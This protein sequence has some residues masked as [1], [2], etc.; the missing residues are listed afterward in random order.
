MVVSKRLDHGSSKLARDDTVYRLGVLVSWLGCRFQKT[1]SRLAGR[2]DTVCSLGS[3]LFRGWVVVSKRLDH[4]SQA[5]MTRFLVW[6]VAFL[7]VGWDLFRGHLSTFPPF[8][9]KNTFPRPDHSTYIYG[10]VDLIRITLS[11]VGLPGVNLII[12]KD[13]LRMMAQNPVAARE[14]A[15]KEKRDIEHFMFPGASIIGAYLRR[16]KGGN[17]LIF[18]QLH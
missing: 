2:D 15:M 7:G 10:G 3:G 13:D 14:G 16:N 6:G 8:H 11:G 18:K 1:G 17:K 5:V 9:L 12:Y 4:G